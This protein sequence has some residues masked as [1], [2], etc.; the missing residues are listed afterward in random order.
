[1]PT[2]TSVK[3]TGFDQLIQALKTLSPKIQ[4]KVGR[5]ALTKACQPIIED[6]KRLVPVDTGELEDSITSVAVRAERDSLKRNIGFRKTASWRAH[7]IEFGT[8]HNAAQPFMRPAL[9]ARHEDAIAV[10]GGEI[11]KGIQAEAAKK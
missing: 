6:A 11:W 5:A 9:D 3:L 1:M 2:V 10:M 7:F 4:R 8:I